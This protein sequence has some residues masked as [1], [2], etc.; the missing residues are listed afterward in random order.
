LP[1]SIATQHRHP[2][3]P[4]GPGQGAFI[5][6][7][8]II[9]IDLRRIAMKKAPDSNILPGQFAYE[10]IREALEKGNLKPGERV[11]EYKVAQ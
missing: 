6:Y 4:L 11:S 1:P 7:A 8:T 3:S 5:I 10:A 2:D 9:N